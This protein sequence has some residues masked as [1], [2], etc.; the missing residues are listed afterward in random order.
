M[1]KSFQPVLVSPVGGEIEEVLSVPASL[2]GGGRLEGPWPIPVSPRSDVR[3]ERPQLVLVSLVQG[4]EEVPAGLFHLGFSLEMGKKRR[5]KLSVTGQNRASS[6]SGYSSPQDLP[7][8][9]PHF[10]EPWATISPCCPLYLFHFWA[11]SVR[12]DGTCM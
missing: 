12:R 7:D 5:L 1:G 9:A 11:R 6:S 4:G 3:R 2:V 8:L 10:L